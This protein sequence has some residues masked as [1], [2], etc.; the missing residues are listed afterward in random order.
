M[1][2]EKKAAYERI[3]ADLQLFRTRRGEE[4]QTNVRACPS[5]GWCLEIVLV[6]KQELP[7]VPEPQHGI[8]TR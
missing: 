8:G 6:D 5:C 2:L 3:I 7:V 1:D 4:R